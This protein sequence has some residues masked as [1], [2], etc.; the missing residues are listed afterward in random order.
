VTAFFVLFGDKMTFY[1]NLFAEV[2]FFLYLCTEDPNAAKY[3]TENHQQEQQ[4]A[5]AL[6]ERTGCRNGYTL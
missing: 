3:G 6:R 5:A 4:S 1:A 2:I